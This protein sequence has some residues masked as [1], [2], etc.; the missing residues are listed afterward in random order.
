MRLL[1]SALLASS[2]ICPGVT[3]NYH[4]L[5]AD[6]GPWPVIFSSLGLTAG[7]VESAG[8]VVARA[9]AKAPQIDPQAILILEGESPFAASLGFRPTANRVAVR[10][11]ED[12]RAPGLKIVWEESADLP[13]FEIPEQARVFARERWLRA[14]LMAGFK[15]GGGAVLWIAAPPGTRGYERFPYLPQ[16]LA[17]LGLDPPFRAR[18]LWA[19]FD[20]S[21]RLRAD[22][23]YLAPKWRASGIAALQVAAWHYWES[24]PASDGY[25]RRL[26]E[27]CHRNAILVYAWFELPHVSEKFWDQHPEWREKTA[28]LQDAQLDWRKLMNLHNP[29]AFAAVAE[30]VRGL[31][32]R[33]DWDGANLAELYFESLE[34]AANPA[35]FTPMNADVRGSFFRAQGFDPADL[36]KIDSPL[37]WKNNSPGLKQFLDFRAALAAR[38]QQAWIEEIERVRQSKPHLDLVLTHVDDRFDSSM[39]EKIG[40]DASRL[41]PLLNKHDFTFLIED[42]ATIWN[43]GPQRYPQ[44]AARYRELTPRQNKLAIDINVVERYQ[45]VYPTKQQTG[46]ELFELVHQASAAFPRV[47]LYFEN[48]IAKIDW[49]LLPAAASTVDQAQFQGGKLTVHALRGAGVRWGGPARV[50]GRLWPVANGDTVWIPAG[51]H[52]LEAAPNPP[53]LLLLDF[54][55]ELTSASVSTDSIQLAYRSSGRALAI[56]E[57]APQGVEIDGVDAHPPTDGNVLV[58]PRGQHIVLLR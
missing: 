21:Y 27:A 39:R 25:L 20:S 30:G 56:L 32:G 41:L 22:P 34:G 29:E 58:L 49:P 45:D 44:I 53:P 18:D 23:D 47:A 31:L 35:R 11:I 4:V 13:V 52:T 54:N 19:F 48:S 12:L 28:L 57:R 50:D 37:Y 5:G 40:A 7:P 2:L 1:V 8:V 17:E 6:S 15:R 9:G 55:G 42:P 16:A 46:T 26:I 24:D 10:G 38:W 43:L 14:P 33:F 51:T 3:L 36:F